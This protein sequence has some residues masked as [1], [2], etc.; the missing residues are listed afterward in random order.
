MNEIIQ[1][2]EQKLPA[3]FS[4]FASI[5]AFESS[6]RM[7]KMLASSSMVPND[8][9]GEA[10]LGNCVIAL[11]MAQRIGASVLAVMQSMIVIHGNPSWKATFVISTINSCG[12]FTPLRYEM[13]G[14]EGSDSWGCRAV[15]ADKQGTVLSGPLV[16]IGLAKAEGW[17]QRNGSKWKTMPEV[18]LRYRAATFWGRQYAPELTLGMRTVDEMEDVLKAEINA[19]G[20]YVVN[21]GISI[22]DIRE[23]AVL[24]GE[25]EYKPEPEPKQTEPGVTEITDPDTGEIGYQNSAGEWWDVEQHSTPPKLNS[26]GTWRRRRGARPQAAKQKEKQPEFA[27]PP[28]DETPPIPE[29][30]F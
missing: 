6:Q 30:E 9:R 12:R 13:V 2:P 4:P 15:A 7:A 18:M 20:D 27:G 1:Q 3:I 19:A 29:V 21:E 22:S 10:G 26:D 25:P 16:T 23:R 14:T 8:F 28:D 5:A 24:N 17:F 11:E